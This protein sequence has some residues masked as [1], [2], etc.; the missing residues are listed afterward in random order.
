MSTVDV[1]AIAAHPDDVEITCGGFM[2]RMADLGH[3]T[4]ILD[5]TRGEM[6]TKG[7]PET[8]MAEAEAAGKILGLA[9][10]DNAGLPDGRLAL[11]DEARRSM[12]AFIRRRRPKLV[13]I[14]PDAQRHPDHNA[15]GDIAYAGIFAAGLKQY[16]LEGEPWRPERILYATSFHATPPTFYV[17][18]TDQF[19]R[20]LEAVAAY[21]SQFAEGAP[22]VYV[23]DLDLREFMTYWARAYGSRSG[24]KYAEAF[25]V[26][27]ALRVDDPL[28][29]LRVR[30]I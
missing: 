25:S 29:E 12:A 1:Y 16:P 6:G 11:T 13:V 3:T 28:V 7:T 20:K 15:A 26:R 2:I 21:H 18:I 24:V 8:R 19:E 17:D 5:L 27:E 4:G 9:V 22:R 30:S 14:P 23:P 10:R